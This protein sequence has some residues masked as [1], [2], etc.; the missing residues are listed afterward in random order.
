MGRLF[1][2]GKTW[3]I[4]YCWRGKE[5]RESS[6]SPKRQAASDLLKKR[7]GEIGRGQLIGP[8]AEKITFEDLASDF[9]AD[10]RLKGN[11]SV[12][13]AE[14]RLAALRAFFGASRAV[15]I[16]STRLRTFAES[17]LE[18]GMSPATVNRDLAV[19]RR[20]F[21]VAIKGGRLQ[22]R[23]HFPMLQEAE[24]RQDFFEAPE[25][26][27]VRAKLPEYAQPVM[28]FAYLTGWR[29]SE[30]LG[31][32]WSS[33]DRAAGAIRLPASQSKNKHGRVLALSAPLKALIERRWQARTVTQKDGTTVLAELVFHRGG[34]RIAG[35]R[36]SW[37]SAC[38]A[39]GF[40]RVVRN[41]DG[42]ERKAPAKLF[43]GLRRTAVRNLVRAGV[44][45]RV[46]MGVTGHLTRSVF[47]RYNV[48]SEADL[49]KATAQLAD[50]VAA[51]PTTPTV[52]PIAVARG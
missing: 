52:V 19:L 47:D 30:I 41:A 8:T 20:M 25:F 23:P 18:E 26:A 13:W 38:I 11:R 50:Y 46:A 39:A 49:R 28:D 15:D 48:T 17:R 42:T 33:V 14:D 10:F 43:H 35:F 3:W 7:L 31:L 36:K 27:A 5:Y 37:A 9:L 16:N 24:P 12:E 1:Q 4:A 44:P 29:K 32:E 22:S 21:S 2:R 6:H 34:K 45:E 40:Y 51:Q